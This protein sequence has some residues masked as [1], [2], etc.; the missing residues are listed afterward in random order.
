MLLGRAI[1]ELLVNVSSNI[2]QKYVIMSSK[3]KH[4]LYVQIQKALYGLLHSALTFYR[5]LVKCLEAYGFHIKPYKPCVTS[6]II[7]DKQMMVVCHVKNWKVPFVYSFEITKFAGYL[8][9]IYLLI[10]VHRG[11]VHAYWVMD[12]KYSYQ[13]TLKVYMVRYLVIVLQ[14]L[15]EHLGEKS[16]IPAYNHLFKVYN[17]RRK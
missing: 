9:S 6:K 10:M 8:S 1:Y 3:G 14:D 7:N 4:L 11:K 17:E 2:Y 12:L 5:N 13:G 15:P 16:A